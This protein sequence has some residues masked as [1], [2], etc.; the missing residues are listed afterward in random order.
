MTTTFVTKP[1]SYT[2]RHRRRSFTARRLAAVSLLSGVWL[3][4]VV[5]GSHMVGVW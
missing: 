4:A 5:A 2:G 1:E 3:T